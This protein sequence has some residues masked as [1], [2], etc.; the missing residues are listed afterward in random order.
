MHSLQK[1]L[2]RMNEH[3]K[4]EHQISLLSHDQ[5]MELEVVNASKVGPKKSF[6]EVQPQ[7]L[8][9]SFRSESKFEV[10]VGLLSSS[11]VFLGDEDRLHAL[12]SFFY[13]NNAAQN[14]FIEGV[15]SLFERAVYLC[16]QP[17]STLVRQQMM[18]SAE[19]V[20]NSKVFKPIQNPKSYAV[21]VANFVYFCTKAPWDVVGLRSFKSAYEC[22]LNVMSEENR[23][24]TQTFISR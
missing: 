14:P 11:C 12:Q 24:I 13:C 2:R 22:L 6:Q 8:P 23:S 9:D 5:F 15:I 16:R 4:R 3:I 7:I 17:G 10:R 21:H 20:V 18:R 1:D 19:N